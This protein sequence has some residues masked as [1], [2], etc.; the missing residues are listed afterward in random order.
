MAYSV[1]DVLRITKSGRKAPLMGL[2]GGHALQ[3]SEAVLE[4]L[5]DA[6]IRYVT[7]THSNTNGWADS[8][9]DEPRW[10]GLNATGRDLVRAMNRLGVLVDLSHVSDSTFYD[11]LAVT[12]SPVILSHSSTRALNP[13]PRNI[14]D[15]MLRALADNGGVIMINFFSR[16]IAQDGT[17]SATLGDILDH[18]DHAVE[19][20]GVDHVGLGSDFDGVPFLPRGMEDATRLPH[21]THGLLQRGYSEEDVRKILGGNTLRVFAEAERVADRLRGEAN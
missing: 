2:E 9:S 13:H 15:D 1:D 12:E 17:N 11:A 5:A 6:G 14:T 4:R 21:I 18:I 19:T 20:A 16:Y 3:A 8:S 10:G 7:L